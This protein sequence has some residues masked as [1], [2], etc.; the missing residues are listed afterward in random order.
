MTDIAL[1]FVLYAAHHAAAQRRFR[2]V[3]HFR[4]L[5]F[6]ADEWQQC[7]VFVHRAQ[8]QPQPGRNVSPEVVV[9]AVQEFIGDARAAVD[10]QQVAFRLQGACPHD[11]R[12]AVGAQRLR[13]VVLDVHGDGRLAGQ[14]HEREAQSPH[15]LVALLRDVGHAGVDA[16]RA[17]R[18]AGKVGEACQPVVRGHAVCDAVAL[19]GEGL[20]PCVPYVY[21]QVHNLMR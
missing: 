7:R 2:V 14:P 21:Y 12:Y 15:F 6:G 13:R 18:A 11:G 1:D 8:P 9:L 19:K 3:S 16:P 17:V 10:D 20:R 4:H 5:A